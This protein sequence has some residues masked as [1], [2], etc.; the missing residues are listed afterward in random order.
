MS[1]TTELVDWTHE[2]KCRK[3]VAALEKNGFT[4]VYCPSGREAFDYILTE[5]V[6]ARSIGFG[7]SLSVVDLQVIDRLREMDKELLIHGLPGLSLEE[8]VAIMR[9]QLTCDLFLTGTNALTLSG[10]LVNID[11]TGNRVASMFFGPRTVIVV[12]GRNKIVDGGVTEAIARVKEWASPPNARRLS[13]KTP[14]ATTGFCSDCNSP[15]RICRIT[16][17]IDRK[18]RLTDL[19]VLVVN[20]DMGL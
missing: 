18:P 11:A 12:A 3:A 5:A 10:W 7:G 2:Q 1:L 20:E 8:R 9:R 19:R 4:A 6:D 16:T 15:D 13:Y 14:C 17:V